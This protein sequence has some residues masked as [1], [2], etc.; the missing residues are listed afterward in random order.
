M[1]EYNMDYQ[2]S[3][4]VISYVVLANDRSLAIVKNKMNVEKKIIKLF[5]TA[6]F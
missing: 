2:K 4:E 6:V 5:F 1:L 3:K